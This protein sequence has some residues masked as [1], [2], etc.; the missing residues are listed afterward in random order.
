MHDINELDRQYEDALQRQ[1]QAEKHTQEAATRLYEARKSEYTAI[2]ADRG[3]SIGMK[4][5]VA[6]HIAVFTGFE[7]SGWFPHKPVPTFT[8]VNKDGTVGWRRKYIHSPRLNDI[9]A[10]TG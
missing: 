2:L 9:E 8:T 10:H 5:S 1:R 6:G 3:V 4:V 7:K